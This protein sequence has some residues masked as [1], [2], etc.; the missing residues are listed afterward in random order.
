[1]SGQDIAD[2]ELSDAELVEVL[3]NHGV[4]RRSLMRVFG[5]GAAVSVLGSTAAAAKGSGKG[6]RIDKV[7]GAPYSADETVP[8]GLVDHEVM[9]HVHDEDIHSGFPIDPESGEEIPAEFFFDPVGLHVNPGDVVRF[10]THNGLHTT[11]AFHPKYGEPPE[12]TLPDRVPTG[13]GFTSPPTSEDDSWLYRFTDPGVYDLLCLPHLFLGM[14]M[15]IVVSG[16]GIVPT[17]NYGTLGFPNAG[18]VLSAAELTPSNIVT[19]G[20]VTWED[21]TL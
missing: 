18:D 11:T 14:V 3:K 10:H 7:Y 6:P 20:M 15:R 4:D 17:E 9:L 19:E 13:Y 21:L 16:D 1:M 8:S 12:F 2:L 5:A